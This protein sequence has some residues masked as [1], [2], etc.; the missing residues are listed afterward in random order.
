[1][2]GGSGTVT[3]FSP[4]TDPSCYDPRMTR[5]QALARRTAGTLK[6]NCVIVITDGP[7]IGVPGFTSPTEIELNPTSPTAIGMTARVHTTYA[8]AEG[9]WPGLYDIDAGGV[10][11]IIRLEDNKGNVVDAPNG[12]NTQNFFPWGFPNTVHDNRING[13]PSLTNWQIPAAAGALISGNQIDTTAGTVLTVDLTGMTVATSQL[14]DNIFEGAGTLKITNAGGQPSDFSDNRVSGLLT[15]INYESG[16][17]PNQFGINNSTFAGGARL[18]VTSTGSA[19][20]GFA[21]D[22]LHLYDGFR[23][24][25]SPGAAVTSTFIGGSDLHGAVVTGTATPHLV[26][27]KPSGT[28]VI[29]QDEF[30]ADI[31]TTIWHF[32]GTG[33]D[34]VRDSKLNGKNGQLLTSTGSDLSIVSS[35]IDDATITNSGSG[36]LTLLDMNIKRASIVL[37]AAST[38]GLV[39]A[40][41]DL[42]GAGTTITQ[43]RTGGTAAD[44][45]NRSE[46][47]YGSITLNGAVD[48][49]M[50]QFFTRMLIRGDVVLNSPAANN[51]PISG[52]EVE[53]NALFNGSA[54]FGVQTA[55]TVG[56]FAVLNTGAFSHTS[57]TVATNA[58]TTLT[59][60]NTNTLRNVG[61]SNVV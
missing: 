38:R 26:I 23:L 4:N 25:V 19:A 49:A 21:I 59:A 22:E 17:A 2:S 41:S 5:A 13:N 20:A 29:D 36:T 3:N 12:G 11:V 37:A 51:T 28:F 33:N 43:N 32:S 16:L 18:D 56:A 46:V 42:N 14:S 60:N 52:L 39:I 50:A 61:F 35:N 48:P 24:Q 54:G 57:V 53:A 40:N 7:T 9:A 58:T 10:G 6:E 8:N 1:M 34:G 47:V 45:I 27:D 55:V 44:T 15:T 31:D 30:N